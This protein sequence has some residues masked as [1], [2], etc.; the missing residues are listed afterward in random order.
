MGR[1]E[2]VGPHTAGTQVV[3]V[4]LGQDTNLPC[5]SHSSLIRAVEWTR[6]DLTPPDY[7]LF[8]YDGH[9]DPTHQAPS[10]R[11]RVE[12]QDRKLKDG[13]LSLT[14]KNIT[15]S[16]LKTYEC[17]ASTGRHKRANIDGPPITT[18][19]LE[20]KTPDSNNGNPTDENYMSG[21]H[22]DG[23]INGGSRETNHVHI[24]LLAGLGL[25]FCL[26]PVVVWG[27]RKGHRTGISGPSAA[28]EAGDGQLI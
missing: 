19:K 26:I 18:I 22:K 20:L 6:E 17:R 28:D 5:E 2:P 11:G 8:H 14:L 15:D 24:G 13:D 27:V 10:L 25:F 1:H 16:D 7:V 21:G 4:E 3:Y 12:L 23:N 9:S